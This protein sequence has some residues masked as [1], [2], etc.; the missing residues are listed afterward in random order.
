M[1]GWDLNFV[2]HVEQPSHMNAY[3]QIDC[4]Y[5]LLA[6]CVVISEADMHLAGKVSGSGDRINQ[7]TDLR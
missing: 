4:C 2:W 1:N 6:F 3:M 7:I 5:A